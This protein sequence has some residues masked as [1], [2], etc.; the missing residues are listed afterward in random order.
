VLAPKTGADIFKGK[1][2]NYF[3]KVQ[4]YSVLQGSIVC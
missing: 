2:L 3:Q 1:E 4:Y